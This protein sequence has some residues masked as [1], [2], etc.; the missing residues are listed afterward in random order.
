MGT[1]S[2]RVPG[3]LNGTAGAA[4]ALEVDAFCDWEVTRSEKTPLTKV[5]SLV[6][7]T[8][9]SC[10]PLGF[11]DMRVMLGVSRVLSCRL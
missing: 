1:I 8:V 9:L 4:A 6:A 3:N 5:A 2:I 11:V 10:F 7:R